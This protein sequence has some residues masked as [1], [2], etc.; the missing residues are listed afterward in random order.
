MTAVLSP[1]DA[2]RRDPMSSAMDD[3]A[4][5]FDFCASFSPIGLMISRSYSGSTDWRAKYD[6]VLYAAFSIV[7]PIYC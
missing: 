1:I 6:E 7:S 3:S 2:L 5:R 4:I